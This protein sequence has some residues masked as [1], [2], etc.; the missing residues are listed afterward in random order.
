[1]SCDTGRTINAG[2][3]IAFLALLVAMVQADSLD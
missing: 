1:M 3:G 2:T